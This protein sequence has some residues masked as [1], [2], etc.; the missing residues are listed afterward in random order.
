[1]VTRLFRIIY[2]AGTWLFLAGALGQFFLAGL[3]VFA[4]P[5]NWGKHREFGFLLGLLALLLIILALIARLPGRMIGM[6]AGL[7]GLFVVQVLL[8]WSPFGSHISYNSLHIIKALHPVN[9]IAL[10][11]VALTLAK[12]AWAFIQMLQV[13]ATLS[14][15]FVESSTD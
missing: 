12:R 6:T 2:L 13:N 4:G 9:G 1:M 8:V 14:E 7:F 10:V 15:K 3:G 5:S 11:L